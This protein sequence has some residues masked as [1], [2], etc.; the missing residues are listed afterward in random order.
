MRHDDT[1]HPG[2]P[3]PAL[4]MRVENRKTYCGRC[5][6]FTR[7]ANGRIVGF[8]FGRLRRV[9]DGR[10]LHIVPV[11]WRMVGFQTWE[12]T[13]ST[14][15]AIRGRFADSELVMEPEAV[16][17]CPRC[18]HAQRLPDGVADPINDSGAMQ[19]GARAVHKQR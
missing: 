13:P 16:F 11:E 14:R 7:S 10:T 17:S 8:R 12:Y 6:P 9:R 4:R 18:G 5:P 2:L 3:T 19:L 1:T 15:G